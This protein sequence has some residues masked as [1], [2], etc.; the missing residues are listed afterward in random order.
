MPDSNVIQVMDDFKVV[1]LNREAAQMDAMANRW[2]VLEQR[3]ESS[4]ELLARQ[5]Q[6][7]QQMGQPV[8]QGALLRLER[9]QELL[10]QINQEWAAY[11]TYALDTITMG[12]GQFGNLGVSHA[13]GS[14]DAAA[15]GLGVGF[16]RLPVEAVENMVG[17]LGNGTPLHTLLLNEAV[18]AAAVDAMSNALLEGTAFGRN[19]RKTARLMADGLAGGLN[20]AL[21]IARTEQLRVYRQAALQQYRASGVVE[22]YQRLA[23]RDSRTC[24]ACL[25]LDGQ[26]YPLGMEMPEHPNGRCTMVPLVVGFPPP[27][28]QRGPEWLQSQSATVQQEI[29]G[30]G[31]YEAWQRGD[32]A[33]SDLATVQRS[34]EW[35]NSLQSTP[36]KDLA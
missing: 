19:P 5:M 18:Q 33:L 30:K 29:L 32:F 14:L 11:T 28:W 7:R 1:L 6:E 26:T 31:R 4:I 3:L 36:L 27:T 2:L 34:A 25:A 24:P 9:Y 21:T 22:G 17:L 8:S 13:L 35:G 20:Q 15:P 12:Q 23:T 16:D 10:A